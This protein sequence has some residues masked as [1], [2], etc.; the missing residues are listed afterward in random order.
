MA[1]CMVSFSQRPRSRPVYRECS[2]L[3]PKVRVGPSP[4]QGRGLFARQP[5]AGGEV[6]KVLGGVVMS[7]AE[8]REWAD[9][10]DRFDAL[11][12]AED[13]NLVL[14]PGDPAGLGNHSCDSNTVMAD[15][16]TVVARRAVAAGEELTID[17]A[18][19]TVHEDWQMLCGCGEPACR[20]VVRGSDWRL[21]E[22]Q[23]RYPG[24]FSPFINRRI[25]G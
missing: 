2:W 9:G 15:E 6:V 13:R 22:V 4:I 10:R 7:D 12:I 5:L 11:A 21:P 25:A 24:R 3:S 20:G 19:M 23:A 16:V 8:F 1:A 14:T 18:L 17:Y